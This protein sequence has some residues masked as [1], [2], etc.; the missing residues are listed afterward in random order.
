[1]FT[2][3]PAYLGEEKNDTI[4]KFII[5]LMYCLFSDA[6][7]VFE[8]LVICDSSVVNMASND[9]HQATYLCDCNSCLATGR[10]TICE[11]SMRRLH[12]RFNNAKVSFLSIKHVHVCYLLA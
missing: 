2:C 3:M 12:M 11:R 6:Q 4:E 7:K 1:M 8:L 9:G 10:Q 5:V